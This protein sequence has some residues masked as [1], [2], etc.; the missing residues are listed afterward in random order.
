MKT[1][2]LL[3]GIAVSACL[4]SL[5]LAQVTV[6]QLSSAPT[7]NLNINQSTFG[8][9]S[10]NVQ[11][12]STEGSLRSITQ[13]FTWNSDLQLDAI[14]LR[15]NVNQNA[16]SAFLLDQ[17]WHMDIQQLSG[18]GEVTGASITSTLA[19]LTFTLPAAAVAPDTYLNFDLNSN[20][21]LTNGVAYGFILYVDASSNP[22]QALFFSRSTIGANPLPGGIGAQNGFSGT[23]PYAST[24]GG[25]NFDFTFYTATAIPEPSSAGLFAALGAGL[26]VGVRRRRGARHV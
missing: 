5:S 14:G 11:A 1:K 6:T 24:Y 15:L 13:T 23:G 21:T 20:L 19:H 26:L 18:T 17:T 8:A 4:T 7:S 12:R 9:S 25:Q 22:G 3:S 2:S 16:A 10:D